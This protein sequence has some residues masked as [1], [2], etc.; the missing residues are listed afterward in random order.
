[1]AGGA[2]VAP[3]QALAALHI[4][5]ELELVELDPRTH[6]LRVLPMH[7]VELGASAIYRRLGELAPGA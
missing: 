2:R 6:A 3:G 4:F 5:R 7:R 1:M